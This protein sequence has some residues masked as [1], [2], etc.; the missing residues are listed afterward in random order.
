MNK[1]HIATAHENGIPDAAH[2]SIFI[3]NNRDAIFIHLNRMLVT[4]N[5]E[6]RVVPFALNPQATVLKNQ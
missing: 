4:P 6:D 3:V 5:Y 1:T 2:H